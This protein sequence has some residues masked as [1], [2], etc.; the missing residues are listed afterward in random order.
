MRPIHRASGVIAALAALLALTIGATGASAAGAP[1]APNPGCFWSSE[2]N[3]T[4]A[5]VGFPNGTI[6][7]YWYDKFTLP[8][9][10]K[11]IFHGK[12]PT[13]RY[14]SFNSYYSSAT[15][16]AARG[17]ASDALYDAQIAPDPGSANP[18]LPGAPRTDDYGR[19][20]T[21]TVS[22]DQ[23]PADPS[24]REPNTL[25][26]GTLPAGQPQPVEILYR[27]YAPDKNFD[28]AG[29]GGVPQP[30][31]VLGDGS[32]L[33]GQAAC[34]A[35]AVET[36]VPVPNTLTP[37]QYYGLTHLPAN[38]TFGFPGSGPQAPAVNPAK[39][40]RPINQCHFQDP[41][42][43]SAGYP[44]VLPT[45]C[46][47]TPALTQ[48]PTKDNAYITS[49]VDRNLGPATGGHNIVVMTGKMPTTVPTFKR[50][51]FYTGGKQM[52]YW[53]ICSNESLVTTRV[54]V[55]DGCAY[56]EQIPLDSQGRY[57]I[58]ISTPAD[59]PSNATEKCGVKWLNWGDGDGASTAPNSNRPTAGLLV[60]R[61]LLPDPSFAEAAQNIPAPGYPAQVAATM[62]AYLPTL[63]YQ[64][65]AQFEAGGCK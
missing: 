57:K 48:W 8:A 14:M 24:Q 59:R 31:L 30:T 9:G 61:N 17:I 1:A 10:A 64:S 5:N 63:D 22:G 37:N 15:D 3:S 41:F 2:I 40:Y 4:T 20:W 58:V 39:W 60:V 18:F 62:G 28:V 56:D 55:T 19:D 36:G 11:V 43:Q 51:P 38:P 13:A 25:Y 52:R 54:T 32:E 65:P 47:N 50:T 35:V 33:T 42:F 27:V 53:G 26:A 23:P 6:T 29:G 49:Y 34:D 45:P 16:P 7:N 21:V 44:G 12:Y 46:P